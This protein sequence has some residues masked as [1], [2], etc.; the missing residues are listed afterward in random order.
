MDA[1]SPGS[2][3]L[4]VGRTY[5]SDLAAHSSGP[6]YPIYDVEHVEANMRPPQQLRRFC[7]HRCCKRLNDGTPDLSS[8]TMSPSRMTLRLPMAAERSYL[9]LRSS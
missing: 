4:C 8:A 2:H 1:T 5:L 6:G 9:Q 3:T 7:G